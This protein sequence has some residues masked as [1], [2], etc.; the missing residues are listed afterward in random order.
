MCAALRK[1]EWVTDPRFATLRARSLHRGERLDL[2]EQA[3]RNLGTTEQVL[4]RLA[5]ASVP[6]GRINTRAQAINE[7]QV[8]HNALL[9]ESRHP[10]A[11]HAMRQPRAAALFGGAALPAGRAAPLLGEHTDEV[12]G[13]AVGAERLAALKSEGVAQTADG[14]VRPPRDAPSRKR[15]SRLHEPV[16]G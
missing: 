13:A 16:S 6:C 10:Y 11:L 7:P 5:A 3:L 2:T 8:V 15:D 9:R 12:L 14:A 4:A 1:P